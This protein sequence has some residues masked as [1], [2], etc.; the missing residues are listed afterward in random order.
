MTGAG[1]VT[2]FVAERRKPP[3][4]SDACL[5]SNTGGIAPFRFNTLKFETDKALEILTIRGSWKPPR[6][7]GAGQRSPTPSE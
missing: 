3:G 4:K 1:G 2:I 5:A 6:R 7:F